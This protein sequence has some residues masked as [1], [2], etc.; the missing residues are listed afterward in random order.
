MKKTLCYF[1]L[2]CISFLGFSQ[3]KDDFKGRYMVEARAD[4][5]KMMAD[6]KS[7]FLGNKVRMTYIHH[8][9]S[10]RSWTYVISNTM[11]RQLRRFITDPQDGESWTSLC[12]EQ[13]VEVNNA[14]AYGN[15][16]HAEFLES[17][18]LAEKDCNCPEQE[19]GN[20][21]PL[22]RGAVDWTGGAPST[23]SGLALAP[24]T[25][26]QDF[27][28]DSDNERVYKLFFGGGETKSW[29]VNLLEGLVRWGVIAG[30]LGY[31]TYRLVDLLDDD[32]G[33]TRNPRPP[34]D[35]PTDFIPGD[36]SGIV[37][38]IGN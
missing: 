32:S 26:T 31:G 9:G 28:L 20:T 21:A 29:A 7:D 38:T 18:K 1:M 36:T 12:L 14:Y 17:I 19:L 23:Y 35:D 10:T 25:S 4:I 8:D 33:N 15:K 11:A 5:V 37:I 2:Y 13:I 27:S 30:I 22:M 24:L 6:S 3:Q 16:K 34:T